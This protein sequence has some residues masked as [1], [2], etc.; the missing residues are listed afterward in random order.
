MDI[1][2]L[3]QVNHFLLGKQYLLDKFDESLIQIVRDICG[4]HATSATIPYLSL[5]SRMSNFKKE[6][7]DEEL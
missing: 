2:S 1:V 5:F 6:A 3:D 4:L 7:L